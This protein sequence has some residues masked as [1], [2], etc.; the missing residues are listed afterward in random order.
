MRIDALQIED[1]QQDHCSK[2]ERRNLSLITVK[3]LIIWVSNKY[4]TDKKYERFNGLK[5]IYLQLM[6]SVYS[7]YTFASNTSNIPMSFLFDSVI[8]FSYCH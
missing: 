1:H 3:E 4:F 2:F 5:T 8:R 6:S 7:V